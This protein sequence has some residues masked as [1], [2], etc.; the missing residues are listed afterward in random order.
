[1]EEVFYYVYANGELLRDFIEKLLL[2]N[3]IIIIQYNN[4][5]NSAI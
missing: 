4:F 2:N 3:I 1:M 5:S